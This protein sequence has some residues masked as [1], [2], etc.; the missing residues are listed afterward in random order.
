[1]VSSCLSVIWKTVSFAFY[2]HA[3]TH[4]VKRSGH[5]VKQAVNPA[6]TVQAHSGGHHRSG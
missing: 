4:E 1:M 5:T 3:S 2:C 6:K